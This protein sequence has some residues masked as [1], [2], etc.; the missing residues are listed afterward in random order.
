MIVTDA[1]HVPTGSA[2]PRSG[3]AGPLLRAWRD[4][5]RRSQLDLALDVGVST[6]HLS[7]VET[8]R[9]KPSP[10][11]VLAIAEHLNVP[12]RERNTLLMA[13]GFAPRFHE[14]PLDAPD[15]ERM[16]T[17]LQRMLDA[18][19][20]YPGV[21]LDRQWNVVLTNMAAAVLASG[22]PPELSGPPL[23]IF[24]VSLH[25]K[26]LASRTL[27]FD[28]WGAYLITQLRRQVSLT[29]D[30]SLAALLDE[31][32]AYPNVA[33]LTARKGWLAWPETSLLIPFRLDFDGIEL[34]MFTTLTT[35]GTPRDITLDEL[36]VELFFPADD[37]TE[38]IL[39]G[40]PATS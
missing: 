10:E 21:V 1:P 7:F 6:R 27:N 15:M 19:N 37:A 11:L 16:T 14:T 40:T 12:L 17:S 23:N 4:R 29:G 30:Q 25:P 35:F 28:E 34:S 3:G 32:S 38:A 20:P 24:R 9:A 36:A 31:V 26:G 5:R 2:R 39:R 8:G 18:H 33:E 13:A 22:L